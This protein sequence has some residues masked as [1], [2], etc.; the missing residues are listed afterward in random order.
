MET[1]PAYR[2]GDNDTVVSADGTGVLCLC[3]VESCNA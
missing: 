2:S 1:N 3:G